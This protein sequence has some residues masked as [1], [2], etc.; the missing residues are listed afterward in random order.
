MIRS[1]MI[2]SVVLMLFASTLA[3]AQWPKEI[4]TK[5]GTIITVY[6]TKP[7]AINGNKLD[8]RAA[9]SAK[10]RAGDDLMFGVFW[11]TATMATNR[12][13]RTVALESVVVNDVKLPGV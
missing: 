12:D 3:F 1:K 13:D 6:R 10:E 8:G 7:E 4:K 11:F 2:L 5:N 9:F